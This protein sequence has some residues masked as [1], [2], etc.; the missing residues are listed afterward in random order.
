MNKA[1]EFGKT[2]TEVMKMKGHNR[3]V[4]SPLKK[5]YAVMLVG[6][7]LFI[8]IMT[9]YSIEFK[10]KRDLAKQ[11]VDLNKDSVGVN[12]GATEGTTEATTTEATEAETEKTT[13]TMNQN[14]VSYDG[15][16]K[17]VWPLTGN[18]L[19]P[20][21]VDSTIYFESLDQYRVNKGIMIE[22]KEGMA[23]KAP[24]NA[25]V[26]EIRK[27]EEYGQTVLLD[28]G[29]GYTAFYGQ[30]KDL[31]VKEGDMVTKNQILGKVAAPTDCFT[32]EGANVYL[33]MEKDK[34][35]INPTSYLE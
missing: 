27:T 28:L 17:L 29:N 6:L 34:K 20:Y 31:A 10:N 21:S 18:I 5:Y 12:N 14:T 9:Y 23:V 15:K 25:K 24:K 8:G 33:Q 11:Q 22:A 4:S 3:D 19:M 35:T 16:T 26:E 32:L 30:L 2:I 1:S 7:A 13:E